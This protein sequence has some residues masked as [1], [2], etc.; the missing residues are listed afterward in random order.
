MK[1]LSTTYSSSVSYQPL[2][3]PS[4]EFVQN[5]TKEIALNLAASLVENANGPFNPATTTTPYVLWGLVSFNLFGTIYIS[6][7]A[8]LYR[9]EIY[10]SPLF[11]A[12]AG[13][14]I[15]NAHI[16]TFNSPSLDPTQFSDFATHNVHNDR[17]LTW[18]QDSAYVTAGVNDFPFTALS[19]LTDTPTQIATATAS[20]I[21]SIAAATASMVSY[22]DYSG[23]ANM[24]ML[25][26]WAYSVIPRVAKSYR[27]DV[28]IQGIVNISSTVP[29]ADV[30][31]T[32]PSYAKPSRDLYI[33]SF[34]FDASDNTYSSFTIKISSSSGNVEVQRV[35]GYTATASTSW[36]ALD[37]IHYI[38]N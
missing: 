4:L 29:T 34:G 14:G 1:F 20:M 10:T 22:V 30:M 8:V 28:S 35:T 23:W 17:Y 37:G 3:A 2:S 32:V 12:V 7:G 27:G 33:P 15:Y 13:T 5:G 24:T 11:S 6:A 18:T 9:G 26:S 36:I 31:F 21:A 19:Y 38:L 16:T 25:N